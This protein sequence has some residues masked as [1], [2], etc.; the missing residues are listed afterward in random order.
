MKTFIRFGFFAVALTFC[1]SAFAA[2][3]ARA[4]GVIPEILKRMEEHRAALKTLRGDVMMVKNNPQLGVQ[5]TTEGNMIY[6]PG[7]SQNDM[8]IRINWT[9]PSVEQLAV[10]KGEYTL[11]TPRLKQAIVG[12]VD[13]AKNSAGASNALSFMSMSKAQLKANYDVKYLGEEALKNGAKTW[14]LLLTPKAVGKYKSAELWVDGNGMPVQAKI[15]ENNNDSTSILLTNL[16]KNETISAKV[17]TIDLPK[18]TN[19][20]KG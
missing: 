15:V 9:K 19:K 10:I 13:G 3:D 18:G 12:K 14:H 4:Q 8:Y 20:V 6:L 1:F 16:R 17:F 11:F 7:K 2:T 5:D